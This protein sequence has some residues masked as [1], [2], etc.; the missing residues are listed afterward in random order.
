MKLN[1][2]RLRRLIK[3][4]YYR[5]LQEADYG[6]GMAK[7]LTHHDM[8]QKESALE[9]AEYDYDEL[10]DEADREAFGGEFGGYGGADLMDSDYAYE[11]EERISELQDEIQRLQGMLSK[12]RMS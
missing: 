4:E 9:D 8:K 6:M 11:L 2:I 5:A 12:K 7:T 1:R 10:K 3:E